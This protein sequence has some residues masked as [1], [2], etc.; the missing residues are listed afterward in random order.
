MKLKKIFQE[1]PPVV[2]TDVLVNVPAFAVLL[3]KLIVR[4]TVLM[5]ARVLVRVHVVA[6]AAVLYVREKVSI[7][8][9]QVCIVKNLNTLLH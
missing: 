5:V 6:V 9:M 7:N 3:V 2:I 1:C 4:E 8:I